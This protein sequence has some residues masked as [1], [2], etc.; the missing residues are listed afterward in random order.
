MTTFSKEI[1]Q[2]FQKFIHSF[3]KK[4]LK[5]LTPAAESHFTFFLVYSNFELENY[6]N[7]EELTWFT[8]TSLSQYISPPKSILAYGWHA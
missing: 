1:F 4:L 5:K 7:K 2:L 3:E 8:G 6:S